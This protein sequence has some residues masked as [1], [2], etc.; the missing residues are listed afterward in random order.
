MESWKNSL[1]T[2]K[3]SLASRMIE[4]ADDQSFV[5]PLCAFVKEVGNS[6]APIKFQDPFHKLSAAVG[7]KILALSKAEA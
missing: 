2:S 7:K 3:Q 5:F 6:S 1:S 4:L